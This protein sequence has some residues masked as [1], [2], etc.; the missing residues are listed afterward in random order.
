MGKAWAESFHG[1]ITRQGPMSAAVRLYAHSFSMIV[2]LFLL[3]HAVASPLPNG[4]HDE[5]SE[6]LVAEAHRVV[7]DARKSDIIVSR[8]MRD[9]EGYAYFLSEPRNKDTW[10]E[11]SLENPDPEV[12]KQRMY[13][14]VSSTNIFDTRMLHDAKQLESDMKAK[15]W[16]QRTHGL[17]G[18]TKSPTAST[19]ARASPISG[20]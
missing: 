8:T 5:W 10:I 1:A 12:A 20:T 14:D 16:Q 4:G 11:N 9:L 17:K 18:P 7:M 6:D 2:P 13:E 3:C 15:F 19:P